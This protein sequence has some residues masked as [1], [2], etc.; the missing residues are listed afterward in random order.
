MLSHKWLV[1]SA[2]PQLFLALV[3]SLCPQCSR[4]ES[5]LPKTGTAATFPYFDPIA[6]SKL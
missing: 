2:N 5:F 4:G 3:F 1:P 6:R